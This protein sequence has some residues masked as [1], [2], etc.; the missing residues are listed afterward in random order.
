MLSAP[1]AA[2]D[3]ALDQAEPLDGKI[4]IDTADQ[5]G[6]GGRGPRRPHGRRSTRRRCR[7][8]RDAKAFN[9]L[10]SGSQ[11][12]ATGRTGPDRVVIFLC[13]DGQALR[14]RP[15]A[16]G[17][18]TPVRKPPS[19]PTNGAARPNFS[20]STSSSACHAVALTRSD[21]G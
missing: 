17:G 4:V 18:F 19:I 2:L 16:D 10:T 6:H 8:A 3:E 1:W 14:L 21:S 15:I 12:R 11:A 5:F 20:R 7:G 13:D 9:T